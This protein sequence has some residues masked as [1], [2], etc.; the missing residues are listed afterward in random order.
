MRGLRIREGRSR[1][2]DV[3]DAPLSR[4]TSPLTLGLRGSEVRTATP[5]SA[6]PLTAD[7]NSRYN[8]SLVAY[9]VVPLYSQRQRLL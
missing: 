3:A 1:A 4:E 5:L 9:H 6:E 7:Y 8:T 2:H